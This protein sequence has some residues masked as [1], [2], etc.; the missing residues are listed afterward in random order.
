MPGDQNH[1]TRIGKAFLSKLEIS[2][3]S[4]QLPADHIRWYGAAA[5]VE[6]S[7]NTDD[8]VLGSGSCAGLDHRIR[9]GSCIPP[10]ATI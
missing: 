9:R 6:T 3:V 8:H 4:A 7:T 5:T 10:N 2:I 1:L